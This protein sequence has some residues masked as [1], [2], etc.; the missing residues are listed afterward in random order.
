MFNRLQQAQ[1][2]GSRATLTSKKSLSRDTISE[3]ADDERSLEHGEP[4]K[5]CNGRVIPCLIIRSPTMCEV[6]QPS[7]GRQPGWPDFVFTFSMSLT[8]THIL[9]SAADYELTEKT[10]GSVHS[11][12]HLDEPELTQRSASVTTVLSAAAIEGTV[13]WEIE[14]LKMHWCAL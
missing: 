13:R 6:K 2:L 5:D 10:V 7:S 11:M 8:L 3:M 14:T 9:Q 1:V 12:L 4:L